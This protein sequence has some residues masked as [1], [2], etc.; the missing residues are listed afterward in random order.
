MA[1]PVIPAVTLCVRRALSLGVVVDLDVLGVDRDRLCG[2]CWWIAKGRLEPPLG[3]PSFVRRGDDLPR[4]ATFRFTED[5]STAAPV[6][7]GVAVGA[8][9]IGS[10]GHGTWK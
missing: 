1:A 6:I 10:Q 2:R 8:G 9:A 7:L 3:W 4:N 5:V